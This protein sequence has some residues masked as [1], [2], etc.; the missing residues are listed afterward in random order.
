MDVNTYFKSLNIN[1][2]I[3]CCRWDQLNRGT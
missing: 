1:I 3:Y 2:I